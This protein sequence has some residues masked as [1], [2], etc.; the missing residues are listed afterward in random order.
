MLRFALLLLVLIVAASAAAKADEPSFQFFEPPAVG[1]GAG[2]EL[3]FQLFDA[4]PVADAPKDERPVAYAYRPAVGATESVSSLAKAADTL[5][6][7]L[8]W[9]AGGGFEANQY[10]VVHYQRPD[11]KWFYQYRA[12]PQAIGKE[13]GKEVASAAPVKAGRWAVQRQCY[14]LSNGQTQCMDVRVWVPEQ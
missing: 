3:D 13:F 5:P 9:R 1:I 8:E 12:T 6:V 7:R 11:G 4:D 10:P 2:E 14:R